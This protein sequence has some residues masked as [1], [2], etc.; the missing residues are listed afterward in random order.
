MVKM[1]KYG[2]D[3]SEHNGYIDWSLASRNIE[4]CFI[5]GGYGKNN[6]DKRFHFNAKE[7]KKY[8]IPFGIYWFSYALSE[9]DALNE[10]EY[11]CL[12]ADDYGPE[13]PICFDWEYDSDNYAK[14]K[15][16][17]ITDED[18]VKFAV[19]FLERV[20]ARGYLPMLY[21]NPDYIH[22][23]GF[24][25]LINIYPLWLAQWGTNKPS[26]KCLYWQTS[27]QGSVNGIRTNVDIDISYEENKQEDFNDIM[28]AAQEK[29]YK[30]AEEIIDGKYGCGNE[31]KNNLKELGYDYELAQSFVNRILG[32]K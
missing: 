25:K 19:A 23:K 21:A 28:D 13:L 22:N 4:F 27:S 5:R 31:R 16:V 24:I 12:L 9:V 20:K 6:I 26:I 15:S 1:S 8:K 7:C 30:V 2:I 14:K 29:Y 32:V 3:I 10:A 11:A 17:V 18:R